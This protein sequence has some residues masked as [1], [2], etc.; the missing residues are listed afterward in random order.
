MDEL[1]LDLSRV[2]RSQGDARLRGDIHTF[3][4]AEMTDKFALELYLLARLGQT[5]CSVNLTEERSDSMHDCHL[6]SASDVCE[7]GVGVKRLSWKVPSEPGVA[8]AELTTDKINL[9]LSP[10]AHCGWMAQGWSF[11]A[12]RAHVDCRQVRGGGW[13]HFRWRV[14][15]GSHPCRQW[16]HPWCSISGRWTRWIS[17]SV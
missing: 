4:D 5:P 14:G 6:R 8:D 17:I 13:H 12:I 9:M 15:A 10:V 7:D 16:C 11:S 1:N 3:T 2:A